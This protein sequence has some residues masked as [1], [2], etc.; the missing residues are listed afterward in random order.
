MRHLMFVATTVLVA[1]AAVACAPATPAPPQPE[2]GASGQPVAAVQ[3]API[4]QGATGCQVPTAELHQIDCVNK[5][6][7]TNVLVEPET[8][9]EVLDKT[10]DFTCNDS[11]TVVDGMTV[12]TCFGKELYSFELKLTGAACG[13]GTLETGTGRCEQGHGYDAGQQCCAPVGTDAA[14]STV[15]TVDLGACPLPRVTTN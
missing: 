10:G 8:A 2:T 13:G 14:G 6:P 4:C 9:F 15:I 5:I 3:A 1:V 7:Y 12:L 11:G